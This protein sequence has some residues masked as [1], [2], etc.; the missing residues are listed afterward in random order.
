MKIARVF[1]RKT[2]ASLD[3]ELTFFKS[4]GV[5]SPNVSEVHISV[6]A[7]QLLRV[8]YPVVGVNEY[9]AVQYG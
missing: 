1:P 6:T 3:D 4:P 7:G 5:P 9:L 2:N 8:G